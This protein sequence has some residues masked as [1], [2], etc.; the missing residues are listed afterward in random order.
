[1]IRFPWKIVFVFATL[2]RFEV[3]F[4]RNQWHQI[5]TLISAIW[6]SYSQVWKSADRCALLWRHSLVRRGTGVRVT[7]TPL[8][9]QISPKQAEK[10]KIY[11]WMLAS[12]LPRLNHSKTPLHSLGHSSAFFAKAPHLKLS[13]RHRHLHGLPRRWPPRIVNSEHISVS[14]L[15]FV[16]E[17]K[18]QSNKTQV[19]KLAHDK[20]VKIIRM[21]LL[22]WKISRQCHLWAPVYTKSG[23]ICKRVWINDPYSLLSVRSGYNMINMLPLQNMEKLERKQQL[24]L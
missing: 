8:H 22:S 20:P 9:R 18:G 2:V 24:R 7:F 3:I 19:F 6:W 4:G 15:A 13:I 11:L 16:L 10:W 1:M 17:M 5:P 12:L 21:L 23:G 14:L